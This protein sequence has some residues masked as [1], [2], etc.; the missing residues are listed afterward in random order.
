VQRLFALFNAL[1]KADSDKR[2]ELCQPAV[3]D[4]GMERIKLDDTIT[5]QVSGDKLMIVH[6]DLRKPVAVPLGSLLR[7]CRRLLRDALQ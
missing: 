1:S 3:H 6:K 4:C 7:W 5:L 2:L